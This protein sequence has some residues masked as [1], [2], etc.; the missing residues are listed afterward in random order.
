MSQSED[1]VEYEM[2]DDEDS[3]DPNSSTAPPPVFNSH[4]RRSAREGDN[5][6]AAGQARGSSQSNQD[7]AS[8]ADSAI[9][10]HN[11][12]RLPGWSKMIM[13]EWEGMPISPIAPIYR[14]RADETMKIWQPWKSGDTGLFVEGDEPR[15]LRSVV[16]NSL[17]TN[18]QIDGR[19]IGDYETQNDPNEHGRQIATAQIIGLITMGMSKGLFTGYPSEMVRKGVAPGDGEAYDKVKKGMDGN[20]QQYTHCPWAQSPHPEDAGRQNTAVMSHGW[21]FEWIYNKD[22]EEGGKRFAYRIWHDTYDHAFSLDELAAAL[23]RENWETGRA[24]RANETSVHRRSTKHTQANK[25]TR[26][27]G[28]PDELERSSA[29]QYHTIKTNDDVLA[30]YVTYSGTSDS[31]H[32]APL[33]GDLE[34]DMP[35]EARTME[36][37]KHE[38]QGG[39]HPLGPCIAL[40][41]KR[42][43]EDPDDPTRN[44]NVLTAGLIVNGKKAD[45]WEKQTRWEN[46]FNNDTNSPD[47][48]RFQPLDALCPHIFACTK[49]AVNNIF[50]APF[51]EPICAATDPGDSLLEMVLEDHGHLPNTEMTVLKEKEG[52]SNEEWNIADDRVRDATVRYFHNYIKNNDAA[53]TFYAERVAEGLLS[54]DTMD[55]TQAEEQKMSMM[56][57]SNR[58]GTNSK[59]NWVI[60]PRQ[61]IKDI[62]EEVNRGF[63]IPQ[64]WYKRKMQ[65]LYAELDRN[66]ERLQRRTEGQ[67]FEFDAEQDHAEE[68]DRVQTEISKVVR[69]NSDAVDKLLRMGLEKVGMAYASKRMRETVPPGWNDVAYK[70]LNDCMAEAARLSTTKIKVRK[71]ASSAATGSPNVAMQ[72]ENGKVSYDTSCFGEWRFWLFWLFSEDCCIKG[73]EVATMMMIYDHAFEPFQQVS[74]YFL[75]CGGA[76]T[77]K[78]MRAMRM[79]DL[80]AEGWIKKSGTTSNRAGMNGG[81]DHLCGRLVYYDE[82][83]SDFG[84]GG[85]NNKERLEYVKR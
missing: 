32:G 33:Y 83:T 41:A 25:S 7:A 14:I 26:T 46:Y 67:D 19:R 8:N 45:V 51:P 27:L 73:T 54:N 55:K 11:N 69:M 49:G 61:A 22:P 74:F 43:F 53:N 50:N 39:T 18:Q 12:D 65:D 56:A 24:G 16:V 29:M 57:Y 37:R 42:R 20:I 3:F 1:D 21:K 13:G 2:S 71:E 36:I 15:Q 62:A 10:S 79:K 77:G 28:N 4:P 64:A 68:A 40:N 75:L 6:T 85:K 66:D 23:M 38:V 80:L 60:E 47:Y 5:G 44:C 52:I 72:Y 78:S 82:M 81:M 35:Y 58:D 84:G 17:L 70:G 48:A 76:G 63:G 30:A 34:R 9:H 59:D 31:N